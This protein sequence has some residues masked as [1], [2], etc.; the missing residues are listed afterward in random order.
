MFS[1]SLHNPR[2]HTITEGVS[3]KELK[4]GT[5]GVGNEAKAMEEYSSLTYSTCFLLTYKTTCPGVVSPTMGWASHIS[6][7]R[8]C[9]TGNQMEA[10]SHLCLVCV[11]LTKKQ[12]KNNKK[13]MR[14]TVKF[15]MS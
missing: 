13:L 1:V 8:K 4:V 9:T 3:G 2:S 11:K 14:T 12:T 5:L 6:D 15:S 7:L 10:F